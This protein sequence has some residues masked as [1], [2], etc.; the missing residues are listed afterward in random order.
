MYNNMTY[1]SADGHAYRRQHA[2][3]PSGLYLTQYLDSFGNLFIMFDG[4][5]EF[6]LTEEEISEIVIFVLG[7][8]NSGLTNW[9][10]DR[11]HEYIAFLEKYAKT[12]YNMTLSK[13]K[14]VITSMRSQIETLSY[15][16]NYGSPR[17]PIDKLVAQLCYPEHGLVESTMSFRAVG[18]SYASAGQCPTFHA[19][20]WQIYKL[21]L[22]YAAFDKV[23]IENARRWL[24]GPFFA[25]VDDVDFEI[26]LLRFPTI[27]EVRAQFD[28]YH[29]PLSYAPKWNYAHFINDPDYVP[30]DALTMHDYEQLNG[31]PVRPVPFLPP[32]VK[33]M[34][35]TLPSGTLPDFV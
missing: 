29:G 8:D 17:R 27:D 1:L 25:T 15:V 28:H 21:F 9:K 13:T 23:N 24:P 3:V 20:C 2:G 19:F 11:V 34:D 7:D 18:L 14:S 32:Q 26:N 10:L 35:A 30:E 22:P 5:L 4:M 12:R 33:S 6:G 31:L 16:C